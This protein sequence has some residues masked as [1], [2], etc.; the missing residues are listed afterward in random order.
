MQDS[1]S[2]NS[3]IPPRSLDQV[4]RDFERHTAPLNLEHAIYPKGSI[5]LEEGIKNDRLHVLLQGEVDLNRKA[6]DGRNILVDTLKP[7]AFLGMLSFWSRADTFSQSK[8]RTEVTCVL[9]NRTQFEQLVQEH[10]AASLALYSLM[11]TGMADRYRNMVLLNMAVTHLSEELEKDRTRLEK[12]IQDL[13]QTRKQLIHKERLALLGQLLAGIAH[14]INNPGTSLKH[15]AE[16]LIQS[17]PQRF[18]AGATFASFPGEGE[19]LNLGLQHQMQ[20]SA[21][22]R[23]NLA[24]LEKQF[25]KLP[26]S[27]LR[28]LLPLD[29]ETQEKLLPELKQAQKSGDLEPAREK[30][31]FFQ[32]GA[33]LKNIEVSIN[34]ISQ[35]IQGLRSYGKP[36]QDQA[37]FQPLPE[38]VNNTLTV[39]NHRLKHYRLELNFEPVPEDLQVPSDLSQ[40]LTNLLVNACEATPEGENIS[41]TTKLEKSDILLIVEDS[42]S[43]IPAHLLQSIFEPNVTTKSTAGQFGLGLGLAISREIVQRFAGT[44]TGENRDPSGARFT[45]RIPREIRVV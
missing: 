27:F 34:R 11:A 30:L 3:S 22:Q 38:L 21:R 13:E 5:I 39:L 28:K 17:F 16:S 4:I 12:T 8:A 42:G 31:A 35:L 36:H 45:L 7:G 44:L 23:E 15:S 43:G 14:E 24:E 20:S 25:P 29:L 10:P 37:D 26:R 32:M 1:S 18:Q 9:M 2:A 33:D 40:V 41:L 19:L 6:K